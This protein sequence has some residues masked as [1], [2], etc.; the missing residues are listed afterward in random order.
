VDNLPNQLTILWPPKTKMRPIPH[1]I[2]LL[3]YTG[4]MMCLRPTGY[5]LDGLMF[6]GWRLSSAGYGIRQIIRR[7]DG[8][9]K[10][11]LNSLFTSIR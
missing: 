11:Q 4:C 2:Y 1:H 3:G 7:C 5:Q 6:Q 8:N 10:E 9:S